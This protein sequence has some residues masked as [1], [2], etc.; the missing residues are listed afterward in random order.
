MTTRKDAS[1]AWYLAPTSRSGQ[2]G[3]LV[4]AGVGLVGCVIFGDGSLGG[5]GQR[6]ALGNVRAQLVGR[7]F[8]VL[9]HDIDLKHIETRTFPSGL[10]TSR[11]RVMGNGQA[12]TE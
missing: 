7:V 2:A 11:Y 6:Q 9:D 3:L 1:V 8:G 12:Q 10:V 5:R 4:I